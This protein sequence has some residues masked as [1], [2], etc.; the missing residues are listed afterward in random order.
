MPIYREEMIR[1]ANRYGWGTTYDLVTGNLQ[2]PAPHGCREQP[3]EGSE[4]M[5]PALL[6]EGPEIREYAEAYETAHQMKAKDV[7]NYPS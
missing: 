2:R 5:R 3:D 7:R 1:K 4:D 6:V